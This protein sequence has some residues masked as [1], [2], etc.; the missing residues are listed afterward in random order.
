MADI[1][2]EICR[3]V[4]HSIV[5]VCNPSCTVCPDWSNSTSTTHECKA[6]ATSSCSLHFLGDFSYTKYIWRS[7]SSTAANTESLRASLTTSSNLCARHHIQ[8]TQLTSFST[9]P[10]SPP[11]DQMLTV[12]PS[13]PIPTSILQSLLYSNGWDAQD[14]QSILKALEESSCRYNLW[15]SNWH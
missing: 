5:F 10:L 7:I 3:N 1:H 14:L 15:S 13:D 2:T 11:G 12:T 4:L 8:K 9:R 6:D